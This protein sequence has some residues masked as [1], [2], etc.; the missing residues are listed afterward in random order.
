MQ[1][2]NNKLKVGTGG[3]SANA[4]QDVFRIRPRARYGIKG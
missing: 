2:R 4:G 1:G 3:M